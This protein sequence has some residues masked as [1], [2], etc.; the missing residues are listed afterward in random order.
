MATSTESDLVFQLTAM[1][2][3]A[4]QGISVDIGHHRRWNRACVTFRWT[5]FAGLLPEER[6]YRLVQVIPEEYRASKLA[7]LVWLELTPSETIEDFLKYPRSEDV[8]GRERRVYSALVRTGFFDRLNSVLGPSPQAECAGGF[9]ETE[10]ILSDEGSSASR[11]RDC[12]LVFIRHG[13]YC[14]CQVLATVQ[15]SLARLYPEQA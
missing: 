4:F 10:S 7:G 8:I 6:F 13:T 5:G 2:R 12:K 3:Q 15:Q 11:I 1:L 9:Q 14:D